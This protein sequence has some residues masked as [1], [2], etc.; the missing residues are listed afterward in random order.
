VQ[1][2]RLPSL[3]LLRGRHEF[4]L[5]ALMHACKGEQGLRIAAVSRMRQPYGAGAMPASVSALSLLPHLRCLELTTAHAAGIAEFARGGF[6]ALRHLTVALRAPIEVDVV[7]VSTR[8]RFVCL[9]TVPP[10]FCDPLMLCNWHGV[11]SLLP[12]MRSSRYSL[13]CRVYRR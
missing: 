10:C 9:V 5:S 6:E 13:R 7:D 4:S 1:S 12:F 8:S 3:T 2:E 11:C